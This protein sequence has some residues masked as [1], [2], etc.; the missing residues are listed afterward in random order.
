M[1]LV[2][3]A[4]FGFEGWVDLYHVAVLVVFGALAWALAVNRMRRKLID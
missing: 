3:H 1:Q 4:V 2:R